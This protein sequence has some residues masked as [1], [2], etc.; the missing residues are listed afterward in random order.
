M[1]VT[2]VYQNPSLLSGVPLESG[3]PSPYREPPSIMGESGT[4]GSLGSL[5]LNLHYKSYQIKFLRVLEMPLG[6]LL[7]SFDVINEL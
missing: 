6:F 1:V 5:L 7:A 4:T 3:N 2:K